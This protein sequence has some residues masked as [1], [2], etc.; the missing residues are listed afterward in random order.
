MTCHGDGVVT[1][2]EGG[3]CCRSACLLSELVG[4]GVQTRDDMHGDSVVTVREAGDCCHNMQAVVSE[5]A[6]AVACWVSCTVFSCGEGFSV[7][8]C[9]QMHCCLMLLKPVHVWDCYV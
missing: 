1:V 7:R 6:A 9:H 2:S 8:M 3:D 4:W 5:T